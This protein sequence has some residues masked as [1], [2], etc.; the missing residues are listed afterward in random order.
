MDKTAKT[1]LNRRFEQMMRFI[2]D[3][4]LK[5]TNEVLSRGFL[6]LVPEKDEVLSLD[7]LGSELDAPETETIGSVDEGI[8][9]LMESY[10]RI[11]GMRLRY[12]RKGRETIAVCLTRVFE[13]EDGT[14]LVY[15]LSKDWIDGPRHPN[16]MIEI[17]RLAKGGMRVRKDGRMR[18]SIS[19]MEFNQA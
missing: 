16:G 1:R 18:E 14:C 6:L 3:N 15:V 19:R 2:M 11:E 17:H 9:K 12:A 5:F 10:E 13:Q 4:E 7:F 8:R